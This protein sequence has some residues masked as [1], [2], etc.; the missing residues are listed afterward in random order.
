[1]ESTL[2]LYHGSRQ[3]TEHPVYH[4]GKPY[5]DYGHGFY[6]TES[7]D[8]AR[9]WSVDWER[10]GFLNQYELQTNRLHILH[11]NDGHYTILHWLAILLEN[12]RFDASSPLAREG[13]AYLLSHFR[14]DYE[15]ADVIIG[16]RADDSYF[17]FASDFINGTISVRQLEQA[18]YLGKL[19]EQVVL[20]S[21][22]SFERIH[23][24]G[25]EPVKWELWYGKKR[26]RD[27]AARNSYRD[28][29][30]EKWVRGDLYMP[31]ILDEEVKEDDPRLRRILY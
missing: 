21:R 25:Y 24:C 2:T 19:G 30:K 4:G 23:F 20:H 12:R 6:C 29:D 14:P 8:L 27:Q 13:R 15:S 22:E 11:L 17:S 1:M 10:S 18:M 16:Y 31:M 3:I 9:E 28:M 26:Q 5:N 7:K